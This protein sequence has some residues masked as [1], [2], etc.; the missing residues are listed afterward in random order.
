VREIGVRVAPQAASFS[1]MSSARGFWPSE[2][3]LAFG[4][5]LSFAFNRILKLQLVG[6]SPADRIAMVAPSAV[7]VVA[8]AFGCWWRRAGP[9]V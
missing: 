6:V 7:I 4:I 5:A 3:R 9:W 1:G 2:P 8:A